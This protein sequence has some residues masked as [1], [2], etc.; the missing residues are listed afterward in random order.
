MGLA[1][2]NPGAGA[3]LGVGIGIAVGSYMDKKAKR[4]GKMI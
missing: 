2:E 1:L 3:A 4:E